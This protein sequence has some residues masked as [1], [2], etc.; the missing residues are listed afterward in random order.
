MS[1]VSA[2]KVV[3]G[4]MSRKLWV[5]KKHKTFYWK[6]WCLPEATGLNSARDISLLNSKL[7]DQIFLGRPSS[8]EAHHEMPL[9]DAYYS[10]HHCGERKPELYYSQTYFKELNPISFYRDSLSG[11]ENAILTGWLCLQTFASVQSQVNAALPRCRLN[12]KQC[13]WRFWRF[14]FCFAI[15]SVFFIK[16]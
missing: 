14:C 12:R 9:S 15:L 6:D 2:L 16:F 8:W 10:P 4:I 1:I 13:F 5:R 7:T 11:R 3:P